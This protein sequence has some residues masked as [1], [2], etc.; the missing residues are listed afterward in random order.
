MKATI[1]IP[2]D[3]AKTYEDAK[4]T[5]GE[6]ISKTFLKCLERELENAKLKT[7]RVVVEIFDEETGRHTKKAFE[8]RFVVGS[9]NNPEN[10][11][12]DPE[13]TGIHDAGHGGYAVAVTKANRLAVLEFNRDGDA[14]QFRV[15]DDFDD[16]KG[17]EVDNR[18]PMYPDT[19]I[20]AVAAE[21]GVEHIEDLDI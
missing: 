5:L 2:D 6:S 17:A 18:Y 7:G 12:F 19:L 13:K 21:V 10:F 4:G 9:A 14:T 11:Y 20:Q 8:G 1:Y 3:Q 16:F 15:H